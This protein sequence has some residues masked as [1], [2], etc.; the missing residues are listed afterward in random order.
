M[1]I[2]YQIGDRVITPDGAGEVVGFDSFL[3]VELI[4]VELDTPISQD[5]LPNSS[6]TN[7]QD[8]NLTQ[9]EHED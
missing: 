4:Q 2:D 6:L 8:Y 3:D 5:W 7:F 9:L 1:R